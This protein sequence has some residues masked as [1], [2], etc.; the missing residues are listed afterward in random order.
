[1]KK[2]LLI[3]ITC[4][5]IYLLYNTIVNGT[6]IGEIAIPSYSSLQAANADLDT[7]EL[8]LQNL[9][10]TDYANKQKD[11][12]RARTEFNSRKRSYE[13]LAAN[14]TDEQL[15]AAM[16]EE[17]FLLD[18]LWILVGNYAND[19]NVKFLMNVNED[20]DYT[21]NFDVT[22]TYISVINFIYDLANDSELRFVIDNIKLE[23]GSNQNTVTK[24]Q[25]TVTGINVVTKDE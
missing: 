22:G 6:T 11:V 24:A 17:K 20:A 16:K 14:A 23:G 15:E 3:I 4:I 13:S 18:Y 5:L 8:A 7:K 19:N 12:Q 21:I 2:I 10:D 9:I 1:M 25:F